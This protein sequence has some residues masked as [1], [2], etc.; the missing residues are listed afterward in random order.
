MILQLAGTMY[1]AWQN[2]NGK[3]RV[4]PFAQHVARVRQAKANRHRIS[5]AWDCFLGCRVYYEL[6]VP[7]KRSERVRM[8]GKPLPLYHEQHRLDAD[9]VFY[10]QSAVDVTPKQ[11]VSCKRIVSYDGRG[12][13]VG[14][15]RLQP[16]LPRQEVMPGGELVV[17]A[18]TEG[19]QVVRP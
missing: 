9:D 14:C 17:F 15:V 12:H 2:R 19:L 5:S 11:C 10:Q 1:Y 13:K 6:H 4:V 7:T 3:V 8:V 18:P 16:M